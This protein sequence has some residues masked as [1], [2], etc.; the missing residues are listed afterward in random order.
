[1]ASD[2]DGIAASIAKSEAGAERINPGRRLSSAATG[3][4]FRF[5]SFWAKEH[6]RAPAPNP[7]AYRPQSR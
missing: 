5:D 7:S 3:S 6:K 1:M 2:I 4:R